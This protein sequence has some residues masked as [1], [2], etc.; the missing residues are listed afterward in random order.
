MYTNV[1]SNII[2]NN[3]KVE[4]TWIPINWWMNKQNVIFP[5][6]G[7]YISHKKEWGTDDTAMWMNLKT[8][9]SLKEARHKR[10]TYCMISVSTIGN[11]IEIESRW[12]V[13]RSY[14]R[15]ID[16]ERR[17]ETANGYR[18]SFWGDENILGLDSGDDC[19]Q[20]SEYTKNHWIVYF[21]RVHFIVYELY[22]KKLFSI[23][24]YPILL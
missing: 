22:L 21:K 10:A 11:S 14:R 20:S 13:A 24:Q 4:T 18:I 6:S 3:Q 9:G 2:H 19:A 7:I 5:Y 15:R 17:R 8:L 12:V 23:C 16:R 1:H